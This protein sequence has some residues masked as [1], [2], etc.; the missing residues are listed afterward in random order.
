MSEYRFESDYT[1]RPADAHPDSPQQPEP[2]IASL[3]LMRAVN[4]ALYL[5]RPLLVEGEVG[6]GKTRLAYAVAYELGLPLYRWF[7]RSTSKVEEG[8]YTYDAVSRLHDVQTASFEQ[9]REPQ[10]KGARVKRRDPADPR[11][12]R[13]F[14]PLGE[15]FQLRD[16]PA[17]VLID[18]IDKASYDFPNDLLNILDQPWEFSIPETG[19]T[20]TALADNLPIVIITSNR[21]KRLPP[22][23]TRRCIYT[24]INLQ[25]SEAD[26]T[27]IIV[28]HY[29]VKGKTEPDPELIKTAIKRFHTIRQDSR[30]SKK[31][32][33]SEFLDWLQVL[34]DPGSLQET[35]TLTQDGPL[36]YPELL[37]KQRED[38]QHYTD[39]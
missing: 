20:V 8:L 37:L 26:L 6:C 4:L 35:E 38:L 14:G 19:E 27:D 11:A 21:E 1:H 22:A 7:V 28:L 29:R 15:A 34:H 13:A 2:Y 23:F 5:R 3:R 32:G 17:V 33:I 25:S 18:E 16:R 30:L 24:V 10:A 36:P 9:R 39:L 31:P 12:Y